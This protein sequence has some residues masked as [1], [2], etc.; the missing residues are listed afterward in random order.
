MLSVYCGETGNESKKR[1]HGGHPFSGARIAL[2]A[3]SCFRAPARI[4][5]PTKSEFWRKRFATCTR[6]YRFP[7]E[8]NVSVCAHVTNQLLNDS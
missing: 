3:W 8:L 4:G 6:L 1:G 2:S 7:N 5:L